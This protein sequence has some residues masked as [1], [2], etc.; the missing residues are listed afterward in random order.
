MFSKA[1]F[2]QTLKSNIKLWAIF[3]TILSVFLF[4][5]IAT[6]DPKMIQ[7]LMDMMGD[8]MGD[9][10]ERFGSMMGENSMFA[11]IGT[12]VGSLSSQFYGMLAT[13]LPMIY[14]LITAN[15]LVAAKVD[16]G[17]MAY[18]LST[19][20]KRTKVVG[21]QAAY[22][23]GSTAAMFLVVTLVGMISVRHKLHR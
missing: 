7:N 10:S 8:V 6:F 17:S 19:P 1:I 13:I 18:L 15:S 22:L 11:N 4:I 21:T 12:L 3:T 5:T 14:I 16:R 20:T 2:K 23:I 9:M